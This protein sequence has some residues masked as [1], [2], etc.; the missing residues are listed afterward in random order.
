MVHWLWVVGAF[1]AGEVAGIWI[2][3][4]LTANEPKSKYIK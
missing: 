4:M 2:F 1:I 3:S